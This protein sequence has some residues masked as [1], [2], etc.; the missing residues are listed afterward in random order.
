MELS[1]ENREAIRQLARRMKEARRV[2][3][4]TG[5]G[6]S[7]DSGLPT[8]R[9][10]GGLYNQEC[11]VEGLAIEELLSGPM[12]QAR[13]D[14]CWR[15][16]AQIEEACRGAQPNIGHRFMAWLERQRGEVVVLT[17][18]VD[19]LHRAAGTQQ[20]IEIHGSIHPLYCV[21]CDW[22]PVW[23][24]TKDYKSRPVVQ[25]VVDWFGLT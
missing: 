13:P 9:G 4:I 12:L 19:G 7:A 16:I 6:L 14:I 3:F 2:L 11:D 15:Y 18:N 10:V 21:E 23:N 25:N 17:Q 24:P 8:Y 20:I 1:S 22:G 5:A